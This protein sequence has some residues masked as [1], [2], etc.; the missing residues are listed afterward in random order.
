MTL[1]SDDTPVILLPDRLDPILEEE[2]PTQR[3]YAWMEIVS[4]RIP[5]I[6]NGAPEDSLEANIGQLYIDK[7]GTQGNRIYFKT[8]NGG[9]D[10]WELA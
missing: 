7:L 8:T 10:G 3:F 2:S 1:K 5:M 6:G 9:K 4:E